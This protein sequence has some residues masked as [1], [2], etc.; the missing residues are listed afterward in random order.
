MDRREQV[1]W[2]LPF[3]VMAVVTVVDVL[4]GPDVGYTPLLSLGPAFASLAG[5]MRRTA[6]I[7]LLALGLGVGLAVYDGILG[8]RRDN[9]TLITI[10]GITAASVLGSV[11]R[12]RRQQE[13]AD[14]RSVADVAQRVLLRPIPPRTGHLIVAVDYISAAAQAR[15]G[16]DLYEV[17]AT[18][19]GVRL[20]VGDVQGKGLDAVETAAVALGAFREAAYGEA[21]L[22]GVADRV[23]SALDR[24]SAEQFVTAILGE[25][26]GDAEIVLLNRG[27]PPPMVIDA[28]GRA[29]LVEPTDPAPPFA[30]RLVDDIPKATEQVAFPPGGQILFYTDGIIEARDS[31]G[32]FYPLLDRAHLLR[33][34]EPDKALGNLRAD[35]LQHGGGHIA[36]DA[37]MLL[38]RRDVRGMPERDAR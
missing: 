18:P 10:A 9:L 15:I 14:V 25:M 28:D 23:E 5:G 20:I 7:G 8:T 21:D 37:A 33:E 17:V 34:T 12:E 19:F 11:L 13:L 2:L 29:R 32:R 6:L 16:G 35:L 27:H 36:D 3:A 30:V 22:A 31:G 4:G 26:S 1:L 38:L 24:L